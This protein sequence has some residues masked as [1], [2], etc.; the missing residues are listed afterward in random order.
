MLELRSFDADDT[1]RTSKFRKAGEIWLEAPALEGLFL[2][3]MKPDGDDDLS[4]FDR[5][6]RRILATVSGG[7]RARWLGCRCWP[8]RMVTPA[9]RFLDTH[10]GC[11]P[12]SSH[13][14]TSDYILGIAGAAPRLEYLRAR[15]ENGYGTPAEV[16]HAMRELARRLPHLR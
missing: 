4:R 11:G 13:G 10:R 9:L 6:P 3:I 2:R 5:R 14:I 15:S 7:L 8:G 16:Q 1:D 12:Y